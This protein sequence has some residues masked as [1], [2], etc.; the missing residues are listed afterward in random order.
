[1]IAIF[2]KCTMKYNVGKDDQWYAVKEGDA[3]PKGIAGQTTMFPGAQLHGQEN[4]GL[5][6]NFKWLKNIA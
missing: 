6:S 4:F 2:I 1:M 5:K 3:R